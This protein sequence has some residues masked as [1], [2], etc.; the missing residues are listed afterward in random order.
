MVVVELLP[1]R[2]SHPHS[3]TDHITDVMVC[4]RDK[5]YSTVKKVKFF[6]HW[7]LGSSAKLL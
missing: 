4:A 5:E 7:D 1:Y 2:Q 3:P 6:L